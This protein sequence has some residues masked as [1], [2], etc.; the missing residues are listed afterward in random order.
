MAGGSGVR[1]SSYGQ[2]ETPEGWTARWEHGTRIR[3]RPRRAAPGARGQDEPAYP[4]R[5]GSRGRS[6]PP[7][8]AVSRGRRLD[9]QLSAHTVGE[10]A[11]LGAPVA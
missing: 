11:R 2:R 9:V 10:V 8:A 1:S 6:R 3:V 4:P 7:D 5:A